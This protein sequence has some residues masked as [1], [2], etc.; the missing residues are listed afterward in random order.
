VKRKTANRWSAVSPYKPQQALGRS[1]A[2]PYL[3]CNNSFNNNMGYYTIYT[4]IKSLPSE[5][6]ER[7][8][9]SNKLSISV[10]FDG[11]TGSKINEKQRK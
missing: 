11:K 7:Q 10:A 1:P 9:K 8:R 4:K 2:E 5:K 3:C 6:L